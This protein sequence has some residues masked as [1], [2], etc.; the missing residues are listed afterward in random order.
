MQTLFDQP[1]EPASLPHNRTAT[2]HAAA[3]TKQRSGTADSD[4]NRIAVFLHT[5]PQ[6]LTRQQ[7]ADDLGL[8]IQSVC[9]RVHELIEA[10]ILVEVGTRKWNGHGSS[11]VLVHHTHAGGKR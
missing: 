11:K 2:S 9:P 5:C 10:G 4:R 7:L 6:G 8:Q 3:E 1:P